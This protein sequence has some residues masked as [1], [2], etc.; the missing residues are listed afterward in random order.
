M[1]YGLHGSCVFK[2][3]IQGNGRNETIVKQPLSTSADFSVIA[4]G[5]VSLQS[6][7]MMSRLT[8]QQGWNQIVDPAA[9]IAS[10]MARSYFAL[11]PPVGSTNKK[12][13]AGSTLDVGVSVNPAL[14]TVL[15]L[16]PGPVG[17]Y[18][19]SD[20]ATGEVCDAWWW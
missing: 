12:V 17:L 19:Y 3:V 4:G 15:A 13:V 10:P 11:V 16:P 20:G 14:A 8:L 1:T 6:P 7:G 9:Y 2:F 5:A 18:V